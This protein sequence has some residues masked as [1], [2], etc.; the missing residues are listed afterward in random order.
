MNTNLL[1]CPTCGSPLYYNKRKEVFQCV[2]GH[3]FSRE[4]LMML[5]LASPKI[6]DVRRYFSELVSLIR[7]EAKR[8]KED[9][10][11][12]SFEAVLISY[13][14]GSRLA[15]FEAGFGLDIGYGDYIG[16]VLYN[17]DGSID[18]KT[19]GSVIDYDS[20]HGI[21]D[22]H[23][24]SQTHL[25][26]A[27][28]GM[29]FQLTKADLL[30]S[31]EIQLVVVREVLKAAGGSL[32]GGQVSKVLGSGA[33]RSWIVFSGK[34][35]ITGPVRDCNPTRRVGR[36]DECQALLLDA[37]LTMGGG[38]L[39]LAIGPPGSG[40]TRTIAETARELASR[41]EK[42]LVLSHT[43]V[44]VDNALEAVLDLGFER[45]YRIGR[46]QKVS[47]KLKPYMLEEKA[48]KLVWNQL[49]TL[50]DRKTELVRMYH[51][52][53]RSCRSLT[54]KATV[55]QCKRDLQT[56]SQEI[57]RVEKVISKMMER[58]VRE[59]L[60]DIGKG[61]VVVGSTIL[62]VAT[63][64]AP[65][66]LQFDTVIVDEASQIPVPLLMLAAGLG[67][68]LVVVGDNRQLPPVFRSLKE[69]E[70]WKAVAFGGF[71]VL[72]NIY[73]GKAFWLRGH[74]RSHPDIIGLASKTFYDGRLVVLTSRREK[75]L[76]LKKDCPRDP[77]VSPEPAVILVDVPGREHYDPRQGSYINDK[78][79]NT[80]VE[81]VRKLA[82]CVKP[83]IYSLGV[84][85]PYRAQARVVRERLEGLIKSWG[86]NW[87]FKREDPLAS[88]VDAF[89]GKER[90]VII[91]SATATSRRTLSFASNPRRLNV[92]ITRAR[93]KL[94]IITNYM[95][96]V[97]EG[98]GTPLHHIVKDLSKTSLE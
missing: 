21:L 48:R 43:N 80:V 44:A 81:V 74:Y 93:R 71:D 62:K 73:G 56:L 49:K 65:A 1:I 75:S 20:Q 3:E 88:T 23:I 67:E 8:A 12:N 27:K 83:H 28:P 33:A 61:G 78:E 66:Q 18:V 2:R 41:G 22:V 96:V 32:R 26:N 36:L 7:E 38:S 68:K 34:A 91:Y 39:A 25:Y 14:R 86:P 46:H 98:K 87:P 53:V 35:I 24:T 58:A 11:K 60:N 95:A 5:W 42:V 69:D 90:D 13:D 59:V 94:I 45:I 37:A 70:E 17:T 72:L 55:S 89:Q 77:I 76:S 54:Q 79:V 63:T 57:S 52:I 15:S 97:D 51:K 82:Q 10:V 30:Q 47:E 16:E 85:T 4:K 9:A 19:I 29:A 40:K 84:I 50:Y 92:A 31:Y 64:I 6:S